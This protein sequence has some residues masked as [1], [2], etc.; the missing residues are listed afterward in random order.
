[1]SCCTASRNSP[2][3]WRK[4][5][6]LAAADRLPCIAPDLRG[7]GHLQHDD[8]HTRFDD[9]VLPYIAQIA[10]AM[11]LGVGARVRDTTKL[12]QWLA[13][14]GADPPQH[15]VRCSGPM[16]SR[17]VVLSRHALRWTRTT[18]FALQ[19]R[20][21]TQLQPRILT[22]QSGLAALHFAPASTTDCIFL[23]EANQRRPMA[24]ARRGVHDLLRA[25]F[26]YKSADW[27]G[28]TLPLP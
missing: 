6:A 10:S 23:P 1:M 18:T 12:L 26:F 7:Y 3:H 16:F 17:S 4:P 19:Q 13:T 2:T 22:F 28:A 25:Q 9:D 5:T 15:G 8:A 27:K 20:Q 11:L 14:T 24:C 21:N